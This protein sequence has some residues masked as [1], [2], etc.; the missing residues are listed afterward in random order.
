[1]LL[2]AIPFWFLA[3]L[4]LVAAAIAL[5]SVWRYLAMAGVAILLIPVLLLWWQSARPDL[6]I[7]PNPADRFF[8]AHFHDDRGEGALSMVPSVFSAG[9]PKTAFI[10]T[11]QS[12]GYA[13]ATT[14]GDGPDR[15]SFEK[16]APASFFCKAGFVIEAVFDASGMV[17]ATAHKWHLCV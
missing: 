8:L 4:G 3:L 1:L 16:A 13:E 14:R 12:Y 10:R 11:L 9:T 17:D 6:Q 7:N 5:R 2:V 15:L